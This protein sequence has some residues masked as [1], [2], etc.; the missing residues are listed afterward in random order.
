MAYWTLRGCFVDCR[1][2][3]LGV[4]EETVGNPSGSLVFLVSPAY[5]AMLA[6]PSFFWR[7]RRWNPGCEKYIWNWGLRIFTKYVKGMARAEV[8]GYQTK[9][10]YI[11]DLEHNRQLN[12][13]LR[14]Q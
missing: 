13:T 4:L 7:M 9:P 6:K 2:A 1:D 11:T 8:G 10:N 12:S 14:L 3:I 5:P